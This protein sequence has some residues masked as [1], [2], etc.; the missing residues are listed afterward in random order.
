[1]QST[2]FTRTRAGVSTVHVMAGAPRT[3][4]AR[5]GDWM[6]RNRSRIAQLQWGIVVLYFV[7][8]AVP[9]FL[10]MPPED[11]RMFTSLTRF[12][13]FAFWGV[14]WPFV[15]ASML[16]IGRFWCGVMCPEGALTEFAGR[17]GKGLPIPRWM[18]WP[19]WPLV[20]FLGTTLYGQLISVYEYPGPVLVI[21]G[22]ST[23]AAIAVGIVYGRGK[24]VWCRYLCPV[25]GV[26]A[27]L[28][29]L[30]PVH[31]KVDRAAWDLQPAHI[32]AVDCPPL[33]NVHALASASQCHSCG[34]CSG[35]RDAVALTLRW[36]GSEIVGSQPGDVGHYEALLLLYGM[37]G[38]AL[39]AFQWTMAPGF[40]QG[41]QWLAT[42]L[43][44]HDIFWPLAS[45]APWWVLTHY[46]QVSDV[47]SWLDGA[48]I[49]AWLTGTAVLVGGF[50]HLV[51]ALGARVV[52]TDWKV[53]ALG[54]VPMAAANLF[55]GL[56]M[57]TLTQLR[58]EGIVFHWLPQARL[59]LLAVAWLG[60]VSLCVGQQRRAGMPVWRSAMATALVGAAAALPVLLWMRALDLL[61]VF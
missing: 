45:N 27:L 38:F 17:P 57:L 54:L 42:W 28:A 34:R 30:A 59:T 41:R 56:S 53:L 58:T 23:V 21:L 18:R 44:D 9:A 20:G 14:W 26:F 48:G 3:R 61:S 16:L 36:P 13:Q 40:V 1:M 32:A 52:R 31:F 35:H 22:G 47:F 46:P 10:P 12:A 5:L 15:I 55:L 39:G 29:R 8:V 37:L 51:I 49:V 50:A 4:L 19:G 7:L 11:A 43:V 25:T 60:C 2:S 33:L 24:R 6:A